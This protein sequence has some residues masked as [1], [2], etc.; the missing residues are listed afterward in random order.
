MRVTERARE[1]LSK[2][3]KALVLLVLLEE[4]FIHFVVICVA[5]KNTLM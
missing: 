4:L 2:H 5:F 1:L 3:F